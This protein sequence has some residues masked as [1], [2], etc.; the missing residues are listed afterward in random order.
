VPVGSIASNLLHHHQRLPAYEPW[1]RNVIYNHLFLFIFHAFAICAACY[2]LKCKF[3]KTNN[4]SSNKHNFKLMCNLMKTDK[5]ELFSLQMEVS[6]CVN[7]V[8]LMIQLK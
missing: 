2:C 7:N 5:T 1:V 4:L 3:H 6:E 8:G